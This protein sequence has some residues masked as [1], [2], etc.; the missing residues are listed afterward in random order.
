[1]PVLLPGQSQKF[2]FTHLLPG[3]DENIW[4]DLDPSEMVKEL[5]DYYAVVKFTDSADTYWQYSWSV[6]E[7]ALTRLAHDYQPKDITVK[8][9]ERGVRI[10]R[11]RVNLVEGHGDQTFTFRALEIP[12]WRRQMGRVR[13]IGRKP[14]PPGR[15]PFNTPPPAIERQSEES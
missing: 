1:M 10:R 8:E 13:R 3:T 15:T 14:P 2:S 4:S 7:V 6:D 5:E 11:R 9:T 12:W